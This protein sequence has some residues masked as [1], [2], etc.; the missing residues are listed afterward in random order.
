MIDFFRSL[1]TFNFFDL[2]NLIMWS[3]T[4]FLI[5]IQNIIHREKKA[6]LMPCIAGCFNLAWEINAFISSGGFWGHWL[7]LLLDI[8]ILIFT[9]RYL[10]ATNRKPWLYLLLILFVAIVF[11]FIFR[12]PNFYGMLLSSFVIDLWMAVEF[13]ICLKAIPHYGKISIAFSKLLGDIGAAIAYSSESPFIMVAGIIVFFLN[14]YYLY[15]SIKH[16]P[17]KKAT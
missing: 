5:I 8:C 9:C 11:A 3:V 14:S 7:W 1:F 16:R 12:V 4:Y 10:K 2:I 13:V 15:S 17:I 6:M